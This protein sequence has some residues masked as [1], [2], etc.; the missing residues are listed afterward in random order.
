LNCIKWGKNRFR[1]PNCFKTFSL[2]KIRKNTKYFDLFVHWINSG[3]S[4]NNLKLISNNNNLSSKTLIRNFHAFLDLP[5]NP[6]KLTSPKH[7]NLK[8]DATHFGKSGCCIV[9]KENKNIIYWLYVNRENYLNY[10]IALS[11]LLELGYL[12]DSVTS[13]KHQSLIAVVRKFLPNT[14]HQLCTVHIQRRC[15]TL[16]TQ[17]PSSQAGVDLLKLVK[18]INQI[19]NHYEQQIF[20]KW[21]ARYEL[22]YKDFLNHKTYS[23]KP[24]GSKTWWFSHKNIRKAFIHL[25]S[26]TPHMFFYLDN[27]NI[28]KDTNGLE[29]E[30]THLKNKLRSHRG[31]NNNRRINMIYWYLYLKNTNKNVH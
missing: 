3:I 11:K 8:V 30:F 1:C 23:T 17:N 31:L 12:I 21:L 7:I 2:T 6:P 13:D 28:P 10:V 14:P 4:I 26:S 18:F 9:F 22:K 20:L 5:P 16:L 24:N 19:N 29:A 27:P 15:Q 25:K